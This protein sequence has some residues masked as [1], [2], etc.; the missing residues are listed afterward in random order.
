MQDEGGVP[1]ACA[2]GCL[3]P[4]PVPGG[5]RLADEE[6]GYGYDDDDQA[7]RDEK[8]RALHA[9]NKPKTRKDY[10]DYSYLNG[11]LD[12]EEEEEDEEHA[13][14]TH[15]SNQPIIKNRKLEVQKKDGSGGKEKKKEA[16]GGKKKKKKGS[17]AKKELRRILQPGTGG[18]GLKSDDWMRGDAAVLSVD[19]PKVNKQ[20]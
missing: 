6:S 4:P 12:E 8:F 16:S 14:S 9:K 10:T 3:P 18:R 11:E 1:V 19:A 7:R 15:W 5:R 2:K 13:S 17:S 20:G